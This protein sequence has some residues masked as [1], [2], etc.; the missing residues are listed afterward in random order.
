M[1]LRKTKHG[2]GKDEDHCSQLL[3]NLSPPRH[4]LQLIGLFW[5]LG[6]GKLLVFLDLHLEKVVVPEQERDMSYKVSAE[7]PV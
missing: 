4:S 1:W 7:P 6:K 3:Q 5:L 2:V